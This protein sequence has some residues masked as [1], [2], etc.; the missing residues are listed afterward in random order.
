MPGVESVIKMC[1]LTERHSGCHL[2][3]GEEATNSSEKRMRGPITPTPGPPPPRLTAIGPWIT[4]SWNYMHIFMDCC[5]HYIYFML[6]IMCV[7]MFMCVSVFIFLYL[8]VYPYAGI[9]I[10][11]CV[12]VC[13]SGSVFVCMCVCMGDET[14]VLSAR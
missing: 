14:L 4:C 2:D 10:Y 5:C 9:P 13:V 3:R 1:P 7:S 6:T 11:T 8:F 12:C